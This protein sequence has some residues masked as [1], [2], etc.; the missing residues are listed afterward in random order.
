MMKM[1]LSFTAVLLLLVAVYSNAQPSSDDEDV[2]LDRYVCGVFICELE[3]GT[4]AID[5]EID[6][7]S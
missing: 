7:L 1:K 2:L 4:A 5:G 6:S 3:K